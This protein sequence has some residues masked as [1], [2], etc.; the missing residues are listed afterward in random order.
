[1]GP[2]STYIHHQI[3]VIFA[4]SGDVNIHSSGFKMATVLEEWTKEEVRAVIR[5]LWAKNVHLLKFIVG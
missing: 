3:A 1:M 5:F 2:V 4:T